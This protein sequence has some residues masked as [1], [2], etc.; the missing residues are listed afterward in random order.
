MTDGAARDREQLRDHR[1]PSPWRTSC[2]CRDDVIVVFVLAEVDSSVHVH[3]ARDPLSAKEL[4]LA[5][6][7]ADSC[8]CQISMTLLSSVPVGAPLRDRAVRRLN[9]DSGRERRVLSAGARPESSIS[10]F[11]QALDMGVVIRRSRILHCNRADG[12][13][14]H[15]LLRAKVGQIQRVESSR[16]ASP[17][18]A[19]MGGL[20]SKTKGRERK[21]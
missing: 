1:G 12:D 3:D 4:S 7:V 21:C 5:A 2:W 10:G 15:V 16:V 18:I 8:Q 13:T 20:G 11:G 19:N 6:L 9:C 14:G 17:T